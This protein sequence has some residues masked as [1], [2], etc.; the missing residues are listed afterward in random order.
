MVTALL[1]AGAAMLR[2][3]F[4]NVTDT[5]N[6][7]TGLEVSWYIPP[8]QHIVEGFLVNGIA[9]PLAL[10]L[11]RAPVRVV[12]PAREVRGASRW[13]LL[14]VLFAVASIAVMTVT[15]FFKCA[16]GTGRC[17]FLLQVRAGG[18]P[19]RAGCADAGGGALV[20]PGDGVMR[21]CARGGG[22]AAVARGRAP[23]PGTSDAAADGA[24]R[25]RDSRATSRTHPSSSSP[26]PAAPPLLSCSTC[27]CTC[28]CAR[29]AV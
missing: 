1:S 12:A 16:T 8:E 28:R 25:R 22:A 11:S 4:P 9:I 17:I 26:S 23:T 13:R 5:P 3:T 20:G 2:A 19:R 10:F 7:R 6:W 24:R 18:R 15:I 21:V 27:T 14:D 29:K